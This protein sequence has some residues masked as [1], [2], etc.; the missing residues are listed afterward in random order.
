MNLDSSIDFD[1]LAD[2]ATPAPSQFYIT[3]HYHHS[4]HQADQP[5]TVSATASN[6]ERTSNEADD[7]HLVHPNTNIDTGATDEQAPSQDKHFIASPDAWSTGLSHHRGNA[8][9]S[10]WREVSRVEIA[11]ESRTEAEPYILWG[12]DRSSGNNGPPNS[13]FTA[14]SSQITHQSDPVYQVG[15]SWSTES[16]VPSQHVSILQPAEPI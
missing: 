3:Q 9:G 10:T 13:D 4:A 1:S 14:K 7:C 6:G 11:A 5:P 12:Y 16:R 15:Q 2:H 8:G